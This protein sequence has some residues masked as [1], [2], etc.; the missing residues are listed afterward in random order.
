MYG[1]S[2]FESSLDASLIFPRVF[3][4]L[5]GGDG[6]IHPP[7]LEALFFFF[8]IYIYFFFLFIS[9]LFIYLFI[10]PKKSL[11][12]GRTFHLC[13]WHKFS[14]TLLGIT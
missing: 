13:N 6:R 14:S 7:L 1:V 12:T 5:Q 9:L 4:L 2:G 11:C 10:F 3:V 8:F